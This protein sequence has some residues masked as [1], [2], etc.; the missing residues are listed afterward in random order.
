MDEFHAHGVRKVLSDNNTNGFYIQQGHIV[1]WHHPSAFLELCSY[2]RLYL[3][4]ESICIP[5]FS[6]TDLIICFF[7]NQR[8]NNNRK[9]LSSFLTENFKVTKVQHLIRKIICPFCKRCHYIS[10]SL[11]SKSKKHIILR[12]G[13]KGPSTKIDSDGSLKN[14]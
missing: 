11:F 5:P 3:F 2:I 1:S 12:N 9:T 14:R 7:L 10:K 6:S 4:L 13:I 8:K